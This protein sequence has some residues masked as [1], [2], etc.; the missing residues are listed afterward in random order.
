[1]ENTI[2][3]RLDA[4]ESRLDKILGIVELLNTI[5]KVNINKEDHL[6]L[7]HQNLNIMNV[8]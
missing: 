6:N 4:I 3:K 2:E 8:I 7:N 1:M 5:I